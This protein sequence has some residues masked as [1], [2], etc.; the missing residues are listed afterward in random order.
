MAYDLYSKFDLE[1]HVR[2]YIHYT[3]VIIRPNGTVE[4]AVPSHQEKLIQIGME[5]YNCSREEFVEKCPL[6]YWLDYL[7]WLLLETGCVC[8][9][10]NNYILP[11]NP[12]RFQKI[13]IENL[14]KA[15]AINVEEKL[16]GNL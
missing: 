4:Y 1:K 10:Y 13:Q 12:T 15:G 9:W 2:K 3:E 11:P 14:R 8:V 7:E 5:K 6:E 16:C